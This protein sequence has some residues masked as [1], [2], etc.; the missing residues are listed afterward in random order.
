MSIRVWCPIEPEI[1]PM[2]K[3]VERDALVWVDRVALYSSQT[4][5]AWVV[6][7]QAADMFGRLTPA[8]A[9]ERIL[10]GA[11]WMYWA[12]AFDD[13][14][15]D[16]GPLSY[17]PEQFVILAGRLNRAMEIPSAAVLSSDPFV[18]AAQDLVQRLRAQATPTQLR[19][20]QA[21]HLTWLFSVTWQIANR[22]QDRLPDLD[23]YLAQRMLTGGNA[24]CYALAEIANGPEIPEAELDSPAVRALTEMAAVICGLDNDIHSAAKENAQDQVEQNILT[25]L[26]HHH[27]YSLEQAIAEAGALRDQIMVRFLGLRDALLPAASTPLRLHLTTFGRSIRAALEVYQYVLRYRSRAAADQDPG[28]PEPPPLIEW[29]NGPTPGRID[30]A[31]LPGIA[32]WWD[33]DL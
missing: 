31:T 17:R 3:Q 30:P 9:P 21:A 13:A 20:F 25:V 23:E 18:H 6:A 2:V 8:A 14:R 28:R 32:W 19:R 5:R 12:L 1:S 4:E 29:T 16:S 22:S 15:M 11:C 24:A 10:L 27:G 26:G 33:R 7:A